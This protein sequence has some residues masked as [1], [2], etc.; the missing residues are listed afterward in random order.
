MTLYIVYFQERLQ[1]SLLFLTWSVWWIP[2]AWSHSLPERPRCHW[3][4]TLS[5]SLEV[6]AQ[7]DVSFSDRLPE[8]WASHVTEALLHSLYFPV[9]SVSFFFSLG[10]LPLPSPPLHRTNSRIRK[11]AMQCHHTCISGLFS[12]LRKFTISKLK[13]AHK[14]WWVIRLYINTFLPHPSLQ[15]SEVNIF[16]LF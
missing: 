13:T 6:A 14:R 11:E 3:Y 10:V 9:S 7:I 16:C 15:T 4:V 8:D 12:Q 5:G 2:F 1:T